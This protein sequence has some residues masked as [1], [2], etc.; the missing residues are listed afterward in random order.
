LEKKNIKRGSPY[1]INL[2]RKKEGREGGGE[3]EGLHHFLR[4]G[5]GREKERECHALRV[6][7]GGERIKGRL[8]KG[9]KRRGKGGEMVL[10]FPLERRIV[11]KKDPLERKREKER[12]K[13]LL[14]F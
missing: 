4:K 1:H 13:E 3:E 7:W 14:T 6:A 2:R 8:Q 10:V 12:G 9:K 11:P 5:E